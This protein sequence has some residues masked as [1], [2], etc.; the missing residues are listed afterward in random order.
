MTRKYV[1]LGLAAGLV[2]ATQWIQPPP[3]RAE[4]PMG[5]RMLT[6]QE[7]ESLPQAKGALGLDVE[8]AEQV[9]DS[10][11]TFEIMRVRRAKP[12]SAGEHAGFRDGDT[13]IAVDG[14]VFPSVAAFAAY[15]GSHPPGSQINIDMIPSGGGPQQAQRVSVVVGS[16]A[17][18]GELESSHAGLSTGAKVAIGAAALFGCYELG[19]FSHRSAPPANANSNAAS[20]TIQR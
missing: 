3:A 1:R 9:T 16:A 12:G 13:I 11:M 2:L 5:Y 7:A 17:R 6:S 19:C 14:R 15:V 4:N 10:G 20:T 18:G 8:R